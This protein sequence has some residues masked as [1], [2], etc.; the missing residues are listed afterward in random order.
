[1]AIFS[2]TIAE[3]IPVSLHRLD[4]RMDRLIQAHY[5]S[6]KKRVY[7]IFVRSPLCMQ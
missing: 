4:L 3:K 1:M 7:E 6:V 5:I 2:N